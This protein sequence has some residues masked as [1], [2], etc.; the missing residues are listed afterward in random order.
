[1]SATVKLSCGHERTYKHSPVRGEAVFCPACQAYQDVDH[2]APSYRLRCGQCTFGA[3]SGSR[4][5]GTHYESAEAAAHKH[6]K[7]RQT[8]VVSILDGQ[9]VVARVV[10]GDAMLPLTL[11]VVPQSQQHQD[12]LRTVTET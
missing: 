11:P 9:V 5:Y 2:A 7:T 12:S 6:I 10:N 1:M 4:G 8:H 3:H